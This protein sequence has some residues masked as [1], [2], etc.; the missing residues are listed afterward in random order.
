MGIFD[1]MKKGAEDV[2]DSADDKFHEAEGY[3]KG[4]TDQAASHN[5]EMCDCGKEGCTC[6]KGECNC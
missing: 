1:D 6:K 3:V 5:E 4:R 2:A